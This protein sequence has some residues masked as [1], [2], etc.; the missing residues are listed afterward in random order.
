M[1]RKFFKELEKEFE[2]TFGDL[3]LGILHNFASPLNGISG[4]SELLEERAKKNELLINNANKIDDR[5]LENS[6]KISYD[7]GLIAKEADRFF[8]LF[9]DVAEKFQRL[10]ETDL[11]RINLSEL[12]EAEMAFL[13]FYPNFKNNIK[14]SLILD[15]NIPEV[16]GIK[17]DYSISLSAIIR[18]VLNSIQESEVMEFVI[19][20]DH[21]DS[22]VFIKIEGTGAPYAG[23]KILENLSSTDQCH[24][25][26]DGEKELFYAM[27]LLKLYGALFQITHESGFN[28]ISIKVPFNT[29]G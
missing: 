28:V 6:K 21:D 9:N 18:H 10:N 4:R 27:S 20:T 16:S 24:H 12:I 11:Q 19:N 14:K 3:I 15:P 2:L 22:Y 8:G 7:V 26:L 13:Q 23:K 5:I 25:D 1:K 29:S 17:A